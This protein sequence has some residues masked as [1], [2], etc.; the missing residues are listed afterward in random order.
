MALEVGAPEKANDFVATCLATKR[1]VMGRGHRAYRVVDPRA[2]VSKRM[3]EMSATEPGLRRVL[4]TLSAVE[5]AFVAPTCAK[6]RSVRANLVLYKGV[7]YLGLGIP[8]E[9]FTATFAASRIFGWLA[10]VVE[11]RA[12]NRLIRPSAHYIGPTPQ[13]PESDE[14]E[15]A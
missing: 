9:L 11:Q 13:D 1:V 7:V 6:K 3:A 4:D 8:K 14:R 2:K 5:A 15:V 10:H 12:D